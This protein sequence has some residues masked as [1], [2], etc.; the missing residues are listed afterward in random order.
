MFSTPH[1]AIVGTGS[2]STVLALLLASKGTPVVVWGHDPDHVASLI[3]TRES[4]HLK[5]CKI[6]QVVRF[7][8]KA[9]V[10]F[11]GA[12]LI[13]S[14]VPT[15]HLRDVWT[16]LAPHLAAHSPAGIGIA[17]F[18]KGIERET[19][20]RP[21]QVIAQAIG[22]AGAGRP[23][24]IVSGPTIAEELARCLPAT[25]CAASTDCA[26]AKLLQE[27]FTA[28]WFRVYTHDDLVGV[29]IAGAL[30][31]CI[32]LAAGVLDGLQAGNNAKSALFARGLSEMARLGV[33]M[34]AKPET[35]F[36]IAGAGDL[37]TTCFSPTGRNRSCGEMLGR[38]M[39]LEQVLEQIPGVVEGVPTVTAAMA[40]ARKHGVEMPI[41]EQVHRVL[42]EN[43]DPM[44]AIGELMRRAPKAEK[45]G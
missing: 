24:A 21:T 6:P 20:L 27:T 31:N 12:S 22:T 36:G 7:T 8:A 43:V 13:V 40:L 4:K 39:K 29:E 15:Q 16:K 33:A 2:M 34:G 11:T 3:Q 44:Q 26:F 10:A 23:L 38:G 41:C 25:V 9:E 42:F 35:F 28:A 17:S 45:V 1:V 18:S 5:G 14:A 37:A 32:A 19:L 30:K